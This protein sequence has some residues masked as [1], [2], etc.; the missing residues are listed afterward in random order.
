MFEDD[1]DRTQQLVFQLCFYIFSESCGISQYISQYASYFEVFAKTRPQCKGCLRVLCF[2]ARFSGKPS[3]NQQSGS[4]QGASE[5]LNPVHLFEAA[6][7]E[8]HLSPSAFHTLITR[9]FGLISLPVWN[10]W[11]GLQF[12]HRQM[13]VAAFTA[14]QRLVSDIRC[15][16]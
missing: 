2:C 7:Q 1:P 3:V 4:K 5:A 10:L 13:A 12:T 9:M 16:T 15:V 14:G 6:L 11:G 8:Q